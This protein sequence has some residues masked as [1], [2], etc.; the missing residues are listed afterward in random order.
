TNL[1]RLR[2]A[3]EGLARSLVDDLVAGDD[4]LAWNGASIALASVPSDPLLEEAEL[5]VFDLETTGL[6]ARSSRI[7]EI[8]AV[9]VRGF[10]IGQTFQTLVRPG[11]PLPAVIGAL[12]GIRDEELRRAPGIE[13]AIRR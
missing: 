7:C 6:S 13:L 1:F 5:V 9:H 2:S 8:G 4:R 3:P 11:I 12:T 10:E